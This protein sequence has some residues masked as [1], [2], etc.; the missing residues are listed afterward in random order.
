MGYSPEELLRCH[1]AVLARA[2]AIKARLQKM[3]FPADAVAPEDD[4]S[5]TAAAA[6]YAALALVVTQEKV[7]MW[8]VTILVAQFY[9]ASDEIHTEQVRDLIRTLVLAQMPTN[10]GV[11]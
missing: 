10:P 6:L 7:P 3:E 9:R 5:V 4:A 11:M 2:T 8:L 1:E